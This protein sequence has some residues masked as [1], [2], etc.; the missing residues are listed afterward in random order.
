MIKVR[1]WSPKTKIMNSNPHSF[2]NLESGV[3]VPRVSGDIIMQST[4]LKDKNGTLIFEGDILDV[5]NKSFDID[6]RHE[7]VRL[8]KYEDNEMYVHDMHFG[9]SVKGM[10][11]IDCIKG[12]SFVI[13]NIHE[14][15]EL[16]E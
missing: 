7:I 2:L 10:P 14:N 12:G 1:I 5:V 11:L 13:G 4:G 6:G 8:C 16:M 3:L 15:I 9:W